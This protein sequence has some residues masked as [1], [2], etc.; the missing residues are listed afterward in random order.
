[1][2]DDPQASVSA[3]TVRPSRAPNVRRLVVLGTVAVIVWL[4]IGTTLALGIAALAAQ[5]RP[6]RIVTTYLSDVQHGRIEAAQRINHQRHLVDEPL[7]TDKAYAGATD[8]VTG[9]RVLGTS[10]SSASARVRASIVQ[11]SGTTVTSFV[12]HRGA[13]SPL[14]FL[15]IDKWVLRSTD[16]SA[17]TVVLGAPGR[18]SATVAGVDLGW[19]GVKMTLHAFPGDYPLKVADTG[20]FFT[21]PGASVDAR[22]FGGHETLKP[23]AQLT[24][25][26]TQAIITA[27]KTWLTACVHSSALE[28]SGCSFHL[29]GAVPA[30]EVWTDRG[31]TLVRPPTIRVSAWDFS[32]HAPTQAD[33]SVGGCWEVTSSPLGAVTFHADYRATAGDSGRIRSDPIP[34]E[35]RGIATSFTDGRAI[36]QSID[37]Q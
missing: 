17:I 25:Q 35:V 26:G 13:G 31:W 30:D 8:R 29:I 20:P 3:S 7:L 11:Q 1:M 6:D 32:C 24:A 10:V 14:G 21:L 15:G 5:S 16:L 18:I 37:W 19:K 4:G 2:L 9:F 22:G 28:P 34:A 23:A 12:L 36:F 33:F 27:G